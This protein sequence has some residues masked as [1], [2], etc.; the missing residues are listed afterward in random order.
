[1]KKKNIMRKRCSVKEGLRFC[2][3]L[4]VP[5]NVNTKTYYFILDS[6][7]QSNCISDSDNALMAEFK[8]DG[9]TIKTY[10]IGSHCYESACG[11]L[12]YSIAGHTFE[13]DFT[14]ISGKTFET[15]NEVFGFAISGMMGIPFMIQHN[16]IINFKK[17]TVSVE[18]S[19]PKEETDEEA[20]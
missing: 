13:E 2:G 10:G 18:V 14:T 15:M 3:M 4:I 17:G 20:A 12:T 5:I 7:S 8:G 16:C 9:E 6:G 11:K 19:M 1:M